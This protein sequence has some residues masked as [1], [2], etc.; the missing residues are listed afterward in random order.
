MHEDF[1]EVHTDYRKTPSGLILPHETGRAILALG[2]QAPTSV[3]ES[4]ATQ[5]G[6]EFEENQGGVFLSP[7]FFVLSALKVA[8][9]RGWQPP[10]AP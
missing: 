4:T 9:E 1:L 8:R 2:L 3:L 10:K 7:D 5:L 6:V